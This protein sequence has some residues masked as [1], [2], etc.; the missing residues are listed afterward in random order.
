LFAV[1]EQ[2]TLLSLLPTAFL[3]QIGDFLAYNEA[4]TII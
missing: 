1:R 2:T 4:G 3:Y